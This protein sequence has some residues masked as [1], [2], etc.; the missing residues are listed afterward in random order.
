MT[1]N[2]IK[3]IISVVLILTFVIALDMIVGVVGKMAF[4]NIPDNQSEFSR[5][6]YSIS[7]TEADCIILGSSHASHHYNPD[8]ISDS[9]QMSV[10]N[11]GRE[12][13]GITYSLALFKAMLSRYTPKMVVLDV[14]YEES[15]EWLSRVRDLKPY[16]KEYPSAMETDVKINGSR[17]YFRLMWNSYKYNSTFLSLLKTYVTGSS[18]N[19]K[20]NGYDP[21]PVKASKVKGVREQEESVKAASPMYKECLAEL[22]SLCKEKGVALF[23]ISSPTLVRFKYK[24]PAEPVI[25]SLGLIYLDHFNDEYFLTHTELFRDEDHLFETGAD[26]FS[27][28]VS[29]EIINVINNKSF[30][31]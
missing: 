21:I 5:M 13:H 11:A 28:R 9:L 14:K 3:A 10:Y 18:A 1:K 12:G 20:C 16:L 17:E 31:E 15:D 26:E 24:S 8:I 29:S 27:K 6:N 23:L 25:D 7:K 4:N 22:S 30:I 19:Y 2:A